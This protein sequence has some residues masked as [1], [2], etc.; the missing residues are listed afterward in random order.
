MSRGFSVTDF[1]ALSLEVDAFFGNTIHKY[2][3]I[4]VD[5]APELQRKFEII[6]EINRLMQESNERNGLRACNPGTTCER[7]RKGRQ[8]IQPWRWRECDPDFRGRQGLG[9]HPHN[10]VMPSYVKYLRNYVTAYFQR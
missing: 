5:R 7:W 8:L 10:D 4:N 9:Y 3:W 2:F 6:F 1:E